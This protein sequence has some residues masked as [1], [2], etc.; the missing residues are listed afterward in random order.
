LHN[1]SHPTYPAI[2]FILLPENACL[3]ACLPACLVVVV[4]VV[5][6]V[7]VGRTH[8]LVELRVLLPSS[9]ESCSLAPPCCPVLLVLIVLLVILIINTL[10]S[11]CSV[12]VLLLLLLPLLP[13]CLLLR[14]F[15]RSCAHDADATQHHRGD[16]LI[17]FIREELR[18]C[19]EMYDKDEVDRRYVETL[20]YITNLIDA[21]RR[22]PHKSRLSCLVPTVTRFFTELDLVKAYDFYNR[23][24]RISSRMFVAPSFNEIRHMLNVAQVHATCS[25]KVRMITFDGDQTLYADGECITNQSIIDSIVRL[26]K[27]G[28]VIAV[29]TAASYGS[30]AEGYELRIALLLE[31]FV[32]AELPREILANFFVGGG[33]CNYMFRCNDHARLTYIP[34]EQWQPGMC[35]RASMPPAARRT[36]AV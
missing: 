30:V 20:A 28:V 3:P 26:M 14:R 33:E 19:F 22:Q 15:L 18:R 21:H 10:S 5:A 7:R 25:R 9:V 4:V 13:F 16:A 23:K 31:E 17:E 27:D 12:V 32:K 11:S 29:V 35:V 2:R 8:N 34:R 36:W 24:T 1:S 6:V